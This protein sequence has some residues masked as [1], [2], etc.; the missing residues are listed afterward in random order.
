MVNAKAKNQK[1]KSKTQLLVLLDAHALIHRAFH[2]LPNLTNAR[3]EPMG[4]TY[5]FATILLRILAELKPDYLAAAFD[6]AGPTFRHVAYE[7]YKAQRPKADDSLV[8]QFSSVRRLCEAFGIPVLEKAGYEADDVIGTIAETA[9]KKD[10]NLKVII[11]TGDLDTLQLVNSQVSVYTMRKGVTDTVIYDEKAVKERYGLAPTQLADY[12]GLRGDPSDNIPGVAGIGEKTASELLRRYGSIEKLHASLKK[13]KLADSIRQKLE[14]QKE[15]ALFSKTLATINKT[16]PISLSLADAVWR[17][18]KNNEKAGK[19]LREF[20]FTS[21][22]R[23]LGYLAEETAKVASEEA[24][25]GAPPATRTVDL[26]RAADFSG[27]PSLGFFLDDDA[28]YLLTPH[29]L[30]RVPQDLL[31]LS[32]LKNTL[33]A[34]RERVFFDQKQVLK[35]FDS[36]I[37]HPADFDILVAVYLLR[38]GERSYTIE[39]AAREAA[40]PA[41]GETAYEKAFIIAEALEK[42]LKEKAL[43]KVFREIEMPLVPIL[44]EIESR[45]MRIDA[46]Y[47]KKLSGKT[48]GELSALEKE[49]HKLAGKEFNI[50]SPR[51][52]SEI[53]FDTLKLDAR[54]VRKTAG[55]AISTDAGELAKLRH[56]H[57]IVDKILE[58][59]EVAKLLGTYIDALPE[60]ISEDGC[61]HT[62]LHQTLTSTGR[63]SSSNP[64]LQNIPARTEFG[65]Q[66]RKA[67]VAREGYLLASF[68]YSQIELR[69]AAA[70]S[71]DEKM[72]QAFLDG[73]DIH[74][75]TAMEVNNVKTAAEV[76]PEMR[77]AAKALN[78]GILYGM[79][80]R[81]F[82][83]SAGIPYAD[84]RRFMQEYFND[85]PRIKEF[86][87]K[88]LE[89]A[90]KNGYVE[91]MLG[92]RRYIPEINAPNWRLRAEAERMAMNMPIQGTATGDIVKL[93]MIAV[94][95]FFKLEAGSRQ[96]GA[97]H[98]LMQVHDELLCEIKAPEVSKVSK[99][100]KGLMEGVYD[101]GVPLVVDVK[102]GD[103]WGE[104]KK[105]E[106]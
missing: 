36:F 61:L 66:I 67:F 47:L 100:I 52:V 74:T 71:G 26:P 85:F 6:M 99:E 104:M 70:M 37:R 28:F 54:N 2:A 83:E 76:T 77:Y 14:G 49:I 21:L 69:V 73:A 41:F 59:R 68:D 8:S 3:G 50:N 12:K 40:I 48:R 1:A 16:V 94:D 105:L 82:S 91:T 103:N 86:M 27:E 31:G 4:A 35:K 97:N 18:A 90:R 34:K 84:A 17:G 93:A 79:G 32:P 20:G 25:G 30:Y 15:E 22:L 64:N 92:R 106:A 63:L 101:I 19:L 11:V 57:P 5:G 53:L 80:P 72:R 56:L 95:K 55:G 46:K 60:L 78:F 13:A 39:R 96:L 87:Q 102:V 81:A 9:A 58:Y 45:G 42:R 44:A 24:A 43:W 75:M 62:T 33:E 89:F 51:Q 23:R 88:T 7:R 29:R 10:K 65:R 98:I 38:A